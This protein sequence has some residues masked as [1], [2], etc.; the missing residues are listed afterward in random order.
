[1]RVER[2]EAQ[3]DI[4]ERLS[5][6]LRDVLEGIKRI[7]SVM[8]S[9]A[10]STS[11][12]SWVSRKLNLP[13]SSASVSHRAERLNPPH[14]RNSVNFMDTPGASRQGTRKRE[15]WAAHSH[16]GFPRLCTALAQCDPFSVSPMCEEWWKGTKMVSCNFLLCNVV[17]ILALNLIKS[18]FVSQ[19]PSGNG[20]INFSETEQTQFGARRWREI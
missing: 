20:K 9:A 13:S 7:G 2:K 8:F 16:N 4:H 17:R 6:Y 12:L 11:W 15:K 5:N 3:K 1:M 19:N 18:N 14:T 10:P